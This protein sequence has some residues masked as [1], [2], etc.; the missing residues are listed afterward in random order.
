MQQRGSNNQGMQNRQQAPHLQEVHTSMVHTSGRST[1]LRSPPLNKGGP[2]QSTESHPRSSSQ[3]S[4]AMWGPHAPIPTSQRP[5]AGLTHS[6]ERRSIRKESSRVRDQ[7]TV[8]NQWT[9]TIAIGLTLCRGCTT[10]LARVEPETVAAVPNPTIRWSPSTWIALSCV[11][12]SSAAP[13]VELI[14]PARGASK[15]W[16][17][18]S[19]SPGRSLLRRN[20]VSHHDHTDLPTGRVLSTTSLTPH[21]RPIQGGRFVR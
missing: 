11:S 18:S 20:T 5:Q 16:N 21:P 13:A 15:L 17:P 8:H 7:R 14:L 3:L 9:Q 1:P 19:A 10:V 4:S 6:G 2:H 12:E